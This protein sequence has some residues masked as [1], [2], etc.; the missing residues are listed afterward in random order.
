MFRNCGEGAYYDPSTR[1]VGL[2]Y[3]LFVG[4]DKLFQRGTVTLSEE[5]I[6]ESVV[7]V[8]L[9]V[10]L[11]EVG[12]ALIDILDIPTTGKEEDAVDDLAAVLLIESG[13]GRR[14]RVRNGLVS[15]SRR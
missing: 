4:I 9:F 6:A 3:E 13:A 15:R 8:G 10:F 7:G 12:H 1:V 5:E 2:C 14:G 11:H